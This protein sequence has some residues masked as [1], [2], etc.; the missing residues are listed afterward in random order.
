[1]GSTSQPGKEHIGQTDPEV[2]KYR[3]AVFVWSDTPDEVGGVYQL[4]ICSLH[5]S[6]GRAQMFVLK[7]RKDLHISLQ[8][9]YVALQNHAAAAEM[10]PFA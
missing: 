1:M 6:K 8:P 5:S 2:L 10:G 7:I 9:C 4:H 3:Q